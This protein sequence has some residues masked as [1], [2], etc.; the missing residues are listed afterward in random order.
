MRIVHVITRL[1]LGGAQENTILTCLEQSRL[2]HDVAL[3]TGPPEGPEGSLLQT[4]GGLPFRTI[5]VPALGRPIRPW[6]DLVAYADL[7]KLLRDLRPDVVHTHSSKAG[8]LGRRAARAVGAPCIVHTIHGL[9]FDDYQSWPVRAAYRAAER[10]ASGWSH[11]LVA[12]CGDMADRAAAAGLAP[13]RSIAVVYSAMDIERFR[14]ARD[15]REVVRARWGVGPQEFVFLKVARLFPMKGHELALSAFADVARRRPNVR[16]V[17]V[18]DGV[19]R[20]ALESLAARAGVSNRVHLEGL[21]PAER[22]AGVIWAADAVVHASLREGLAR[23]IVEAGL[24]RRPVVAYDIGGASEVL[25]HGE[26]G[27]L[28]PPPPRA[29]ALASA[30]L[31]AWRPLADAMDRLAADPQAAMRMG[32]RW[33]DQTLSRFD[34]RLATAEILRLYDEVLRVQ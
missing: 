4:V 8:I 6:A 1:I 21:V 12:V 15:Q 2:G 32:D 34:Y 24:C 13:R 22:V 30:T 17:L 29:V 23:V 16:L 20:P 28:L 5:L 26:N 10:L 9:P 25:R 27:F 31:Q 33:N 18:G 14:S 11:R 19:L 7:V 3:L